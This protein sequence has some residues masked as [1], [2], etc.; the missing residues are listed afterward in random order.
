[1]LFSVLIPLY[2][3]EKY[4]GECIDSVLAQSCDDFEIVIVNDGSTDKSADIADNYQ[5]KHPGIIRVIHKENTGVLLTRRRLIQEAKGDYIVWIDA[6]DVYKPELLSDLRNEI[7]KNKPDVIVFNFEELYNPEKIVYSLDV[8]D[9]F[10]FRSE[11]KHKI[12]T[13]LILGRDMNELFTKCIRREIIDIEVDYSQYK[14]VRMGDDLFCLIPIFDVAEKIEYLNKSYY[15]YRIVSTSITHTQTYLRYY[16]Y[17]TIFERESKYLEKWG[18]SPEETAK[19]KNKF[20]NSAIDNLVLCV[21][22]KNTKRKEF[23]DFAKD[24][25]TIEEKNTIFSDSPRKLTSKAYQYFYNLFIKKHYVR[26]YYSIIIINK[27]SKIKH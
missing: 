8:P 14:H 25:A 19:V 23:L 27:I 4:I 13:K 26:L 11:D 6:D 15:R 16:S 3:A 24:I 17:R 21:K 9:K 10:N 1:M 2:N 18:F 12:Y 5:K 20:A 7:Y 22:S